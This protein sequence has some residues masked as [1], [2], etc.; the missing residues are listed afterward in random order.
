MYG[1]RD[2]EAGFIRSTLSQTKHSDGTSN[3][4]KTTLCGKVS[5]M[6]VQRRRR[7]LGGIRKTH[8]HKLQKVAS[9]LHR[10]GDHN[11]SLRMAI[12]QC[13]QYSQNRWQ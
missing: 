7:K 6:L 3:V 4:D 1:W 8:A 12:K 13:S 9:L 11:D 10:V 5:K 2:T